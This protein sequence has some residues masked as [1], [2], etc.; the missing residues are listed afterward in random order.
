MKKLLNE[1]SDQQDRFLPLKE[2]AT[3]LCCTT[4]TLRRWRAAGR[5]PQ[6]V[7]LGKPG[8]WRST[9]DAFLGRDQASSQSAQA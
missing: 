6:P 8:Y 7:G 3:Y 4:Q 1:F 5:L 2:A 9:L